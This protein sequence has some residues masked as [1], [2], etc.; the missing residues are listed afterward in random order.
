MREKER[1]KNINVWLPLVCPQ[2]GT[3]PAISYVPQLGIELATLW[4]AGRCSAHWTISVRVNFLFLLTL[5]SWVFCCL[6]LKEFINPTA[7]CHHQALFRKSNHVIIKSQHSDKLFTEQGTFQSAL[8][9]FKALDYNPFLKLW[10]LKQTMPLTKYPW[11]FLNLLL[12][13]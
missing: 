10:V 4:F 9:Y 2:L 3:W 1:E 5:L 6:Q 13:I 7:F 11:Q 12:F 8:V